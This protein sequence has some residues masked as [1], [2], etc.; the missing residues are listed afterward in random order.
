MEV[1]NSAIQSSVKKLNNIYFEN[2][3]NKDKYFHNIINSLQNDNFENLL[4]NF[5]E[6]VIAEVDKMIGKG[7]Y[8]DFI[9]YHDD[10]STKK[11]NN[12]PRYKQL[13]KAKHDENQRLAEIWHNVNKDLVEEVLFFIN[14][15][16]N[17]IYLDEDDNEVYVENL[18]LNRF[19]YKQELNILSVFILELK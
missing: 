14:K 4:F 9:F 16:I 11:L 10:Y 18:F 5:K 12:K 7:D 2:K 3:R 17:F 13:R 8:E 19:F 15:Q 6:F 1:T